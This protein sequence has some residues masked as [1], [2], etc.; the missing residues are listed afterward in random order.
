MYVPPLRPRQLL[1]SLC[2][3]CALHCLYIICSSHLKLTLV[4]SQCR[5]LQACVS[6]PTAKGYLWVMANSRNNRNANGLPQHAAECYAEYWTRIGFQ[7]ICDVTNH[8]SQIQFSM[9]TKKIV[10]F[11]SD[12]ETYNGQH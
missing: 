3:S 6:V 5:L 11:S 2:S 4:A 1:L 10:T 8:I 9:S 7:T 12:C